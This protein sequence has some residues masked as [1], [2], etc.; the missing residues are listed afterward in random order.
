MATA[1]R[2]GAALVGKSGGKGA[3]EM[4]TSMQGQKEK[5][6]KGGG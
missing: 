5:K 1:A 2:V 3:E 4:L 6:K